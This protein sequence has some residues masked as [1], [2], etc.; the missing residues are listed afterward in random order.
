MDNKRES[1]QPTKEETNK[2]ES[3]MTE[4]EERATQIRQK[5]F[6]KIKN[7]DFIERSSLETGPITNRKFDDF[8]FMAGGRVINFSSYLEAI[9]SKTCKLF[10]MRIEGT[11]DGKEI[12]LAE[13]RKL[14]Q[15]RG[16]G[17]SKCFYHDKNEC[18]DGSRAKYIG[19]FDGETL[20]EEQAKT[21]H[22]RLA[23]VE[24]YKNAAT[25]LEAEGELEWEKSE[26]DREKEK[27]LQEKEHKRIL[28]DLL[29]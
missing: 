1:Y 22:Q 27:E 20:T 16:I 13:V 18:E 9:E 29:E 12:I 28:G 2:A 19:V 11:V 14:C 8:G 7:P 25:M 23:A 4:T 3:M 5:Y 17:D 26:T 6:E 21:I 10:G 24:L 15:F